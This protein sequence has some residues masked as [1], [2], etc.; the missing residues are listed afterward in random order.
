MCKRE[1]T[2]P[3]LESVQKGSYAR[4]TKFRRAEL[5]EPSMMPVETSYNA[6]DGTFR[7][8]SNTADLI[9]DYMQAHPE[10][11]SMKYTELQPY[12]L[13]EP[14]VNQKKSPGLPA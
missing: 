12:Y 8:D 3:L 7:I 9:I 5:A 6:A 13:R 11:Q 1:C 2:K 4:L 10:L 14:S